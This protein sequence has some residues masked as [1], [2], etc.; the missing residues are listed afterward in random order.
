MLCG[1]VANVE[2]LAS[3]DRPNVVRVKGDHS[4]SG[5]TTGNEFDLEGL[6][7]IVN[8]HNRADITGLETM[9]GQ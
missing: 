8:V 6:P 7:G 9:F 5:S 4:K 2:N 1:N 3:R